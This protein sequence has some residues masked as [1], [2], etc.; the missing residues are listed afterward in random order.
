MNR[1][2]HFIQWA[3]CA[4]QFEPADTPPICKAL[5]DDCHKYGHTA[6]IGS[7]ELAEI[8]AAWSALP[9]PLRAA[10]LAIVRSQNGVRK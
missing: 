6:E 3:W 1:A 9:E 8:G 4:V 2:S 7:E 10:V 5:R